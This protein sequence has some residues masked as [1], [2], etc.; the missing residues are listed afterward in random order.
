MRAN[1]IYLQTNS[2]IVN[3]QVHELDEMIIVKPDISPVGHDQNFWPRH[4]PDH[5]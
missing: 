1:K 3:S 4:L 2:W 5:C